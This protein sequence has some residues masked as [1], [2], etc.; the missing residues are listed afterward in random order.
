MTGSL[1]ASQ[2]VMPP[3]SSIRLVMP[4]WLRMETA[5]EER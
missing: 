3:A 4:C 1:A 2:A 5:M